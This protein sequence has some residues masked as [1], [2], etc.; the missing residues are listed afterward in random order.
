MIA[1]YHH[2]ERIDDTEPKKRQWLKQKDFLEP[3][4]AA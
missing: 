3:A 4:V 1:P 2:D